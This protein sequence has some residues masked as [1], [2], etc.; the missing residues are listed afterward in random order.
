MRDSRHARIRR[1][2]H[3]STACRHI[4]YPAGGTCGGNAPRR[5]TQT[6]AAERHI[7][8]NQVGWRHKL[9]FAQPAKLLKTGETSGFTMLGSVV[10]PIPF[11][12]LVVF[13]SFRDVCRLLGLKGGEPKKINGMLPEA[14]RFFHTSARDP[15]TVLSFAGPVVSALGARYQPPPEPNTQITGHCGKME[16]GIG[17]PMSHAPVSHTYYYKVGSTHRRRNRETQIAGCVF[18]SSGLSPR[19]FPP[20][21]LPSRL[22][23]HM[24]MRRDGDDARA[25]RLPETVPQQYANCRTVG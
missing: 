23:P 3:G 20:R 14:S 5:G 16:N 15:Q 4:P 13:A 9:C 17:Y 24:D 18:P 8:A 19:L 25:H 21:R 11:Q 6:G 1:L 22:T 2:C 12:R 7:P 10:Q